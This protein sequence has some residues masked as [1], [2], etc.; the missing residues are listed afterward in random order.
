MFN[1]LCSV[2]NLAGLGRGNGGH[3]QG[4]GE[5]IGNTFVSGVRLPGKPGVGGE[6]EG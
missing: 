2:F 5:V 4:R 3:V 6:P 1:S